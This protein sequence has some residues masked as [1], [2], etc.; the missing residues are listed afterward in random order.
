MHVVV[1]V[2]LAMLCVYAHENHEGPFNNSMP[3]VAILIRHTLASLA[4][5]GLCPSVGVAACD[6]RQGGCHG[7]V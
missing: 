4:R 6:G 5:V 7:Q 2:Y 3:R 1:H